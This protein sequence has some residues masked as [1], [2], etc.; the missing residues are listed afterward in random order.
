M[1][2][3]TALILGATLLGPAVAEAQVQPN[4]SYEVTIYQRG[5]TNVVSTATIPASQVVCGLVPSAPVTTLVANP[6]QLIF[7]HPGDGLDCVYTDPGNGPLRSLPV[8]TQEYDAKVAATNPV[9]TG[10]A[11]A[12]SNPFWLPGLRPAILTNVRVTRSS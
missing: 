11:S 5:T 4:T 8:G 10:D 9:G 1:R 12:S 3:T 7:T 2:Y 6:N